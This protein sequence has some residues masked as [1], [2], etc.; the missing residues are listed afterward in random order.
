VFEQGRQRL[1]IGIREVAER[2]V[3]AWTITFRAAVGVE[4]LTIVRKITGR[5]HDRVYAYQHGLAS[6]NE[7]DESL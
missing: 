3:V 7:V 5:G 4:S 1:V 6:L 2:P